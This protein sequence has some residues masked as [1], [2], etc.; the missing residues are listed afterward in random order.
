MG[1]AIGVAVALVTVVASSGCHKGF[2][3]GVTQPNPLSQPL[4]TLRESERLTIVTGDMEL[5]MPM[6]AGGDPRTGGSIMQN[7]RYPL[8]NSA[9]FTVVSR[10]RLRFHVQIEHKWQDYAKLTEWNAYLI[11]DE[12]RVYLPQ[13]VDFLQPRHVVFMWDYETRTAVRNRFGDVVSVNND[14]HRRRQTLGSLS[15]FR[16][17]G[18]FVFYGR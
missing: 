7:R 11:D 13:E 18:D 15:L 2:S 16:G 1:R 8:Q 5:E 12:G 3:A 6:Q 9:S 10:D 14:G 17:R 4:E